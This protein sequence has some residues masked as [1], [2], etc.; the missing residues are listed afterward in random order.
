MEAVRTARAPL[1]QAFDD[2]NRATTRKAVLLVTDGQPTFLRRNNDVDC[3]RNP[4]DNATLPDPNGNTNA[5]GGPFTNGC[6]QGVPIYK[7]SSAYPWMYRIKLTS[8]SSSCYIP[9]PSTWTSTNC[10][11]SWPT[12]TNN[13][14]LYKDIIRC[15]RSLINC[16]G[17]NGAMYEANLVRNCGYG[18]SS[19]GGG[20]AHD[21]IFFAIAI[22]KKDLTDPQSSLDENAKC[23]LARMANATDVL[24][25][26][27]GVVETMADVCNAV[28][29]TTV[30]GDTHA[31][32]KEGWPCGT[33]PC[34][35]SAQQKGKVY[36]IDLN[37]D[38]TAQLQIAFQEIAALLKLRLVL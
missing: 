27:T 31:D 38:V 16:A 12:V 9:I 30:D 20:G 19:C 21:V 26:A 3:K 5:G 36:I 34:I 15:T 33:G 4:K 1:A 14:Q 8:S 13:P 37:G 24:H 28:F 22:G 18:N 10:M 23:M 25:T 32:L 35:N 17:T 11:S 29:T 2:P 7:S 6:S